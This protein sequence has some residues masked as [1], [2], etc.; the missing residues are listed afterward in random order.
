MNPEVEN[1][2]CLRHDVDHDL[3]IAL[4]MAYEEHKRGI[5]ST[6]FILHDHSYC[7]DPLFIEKILQI[8]D[9]GHEIGLHLNVIAG[10]IKGEYR[11]PDQHLSAW[12][13]RLRESNVDIKGSATHGDPLCYE[14]GF[15]NNW[16]FKQSKNEIGSE[17]ALSAEGVPD[18]SGRKSISCELAKEEKLLASIGEISLFTRDMSDFGL[19]YE[20]VNL[21]ANYW[22][23]TGKDWHRT[24]DPLDQDLSIG[25]HQ[26]LMHPIH[27]VGE[28]RKIFFLSTARTGSK[29]LAAALAKVSSAEVKHEFTLNH[30]Y[31]SGIETQEK[32]ASIDYA[33]LAKKE[34][35]TQNLIKYSLKKMDK[36]VKDKVEINVYLEEFKEQLT[37]ISPKAELYGLV[38]DGREVVASLLSRN[39]YSTTDSVRY[40]RNEYFSNFGFSQIEKAMAYWGDTYSDIIGAGIQVFRIED[41]GS[42]KEGMTKFLKALSLPAHPR[43]IEHIDFE[44]IDTSV[45]KAKYDSSNWNSSHKESFLRLAGRSMKF[46]GYGL[47]DEHSDGSSQD[48]TLDT[49]GFNSTKVHS[50][51][52]LGLEKMSS[53]KVS[54]SMNQEKGLSINLDASSQ[55]GW[56]IFSNDEK[57]TWSKL[58]DSY[59]QIKSQEPQQIEGSI[60]FEVSDDLLCRVFLLAY[61]QD[62]ELQSKKLATILAPG[63]RGIFYEKIDN[64]A[65]F[66]LIG[67]HFAWRNQE[68]KKNGRLDLASFRLETSRV[69]PGYWFANS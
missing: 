32:L 56:I 1:V 16:F 3:D 63:W 64:D 43:L 53:S 22:T 11:D 36:G 8:Q 37:R 47:W 31:R 40:P 2:I 27:W 59:C 61:G 17:C 12:L 49:V 34:S 48:Q 4:D 50:Q 60:K 6:Y 26:I 18:P 55:S 65:V 66:P 28:P 42:S 57:T 30:R 38:R 29:W 51:D 9:Y 10:W 58:S 25:R 39:W 5:K 46:C 68:S 45:S 20:A 35:Y 7:E 33:A 13:D 19:E 44:P 14:Y 54:M 52:L 24:G 23:D 62:G 41:I 21:D 15:I 69:T 67:I